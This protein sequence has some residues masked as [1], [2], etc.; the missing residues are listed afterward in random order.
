MFRTIFCLLL[1]LIIGI[2]I[3]FI[4]DNQYIIKLAK[5]SLPKVFYTNIIYDWQN[6]NNGIILKSNNPQQWIIHKYYNQIP[7]TK[8]L[9]KELKSN[10][11][12]SFLIIKNGKLIYEYY[13]KNHQEKKLSNSFSLSKS[14]VSLLL[15]FAIQDGYIKSIN[16]YII[17]FLPEY[18]GTLYSNQVKIVDLLQM[19]SG[20]DWKE[21]YNNL[22]NNL[23]AKVYYGNNIEKLIF[24][25]K[26][27]KKPGINFKYIT[28]NTQILTILL[29]RAIKKKLI[30][31]A[32]EK[33]W[34]PLGMNQNALWR[35]DKKN[36]IGK[37]FCCLYSIAKDYA[38]LGQFLL[39]K[40]KWKGKQILNKNFIYKMIHPG[41]IQK[42]GYGIWINYNSN[43]EFYL[44]MGYYGQYIIIIPKHNIVIVRLG[45]KQNNN[46]Y[47]TNKIIQKDVYIYIKEVLKIIKTYN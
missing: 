3:I 20:L 36:S 5:V 24:S 14:I 25:K 32:N 44:Y 6:F 17:D 26:F 27:I 45:E 43:P 16:Q 7:L 23:L 29:Y 46:L 10:K 2:F 11:S 35:L 9:K 18:K 39:Q 33:M 13:W 41:I 19:S 12:T 28:A 1:F 47:S 42:Y 37:E 15:G 8:I 30:I 40:G 31:Y 21:N 34:N 38:K 22:F 4:T